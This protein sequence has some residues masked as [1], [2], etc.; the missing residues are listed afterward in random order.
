M[1]LPKSLSAPHVQEPMPPEPPATKPPILAVAKVEGI[2]RNSCP[3][4]ARVA[5][6]RSL[7]MMPGSAT[8][9]PGPISLTRAMF[10]MCITQP[11]RSG[12]ACP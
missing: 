12:I 7:M 5:A 3:E 4:W 10:F 2:M 1:M 11:P 6:S 8:T 9:R